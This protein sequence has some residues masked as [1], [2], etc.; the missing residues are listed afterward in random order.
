MK[1][2]V[3]PINDELMERYNIMPGRV[4]YLLKVINDSTGLF[5]VKDRLDTYSRIDIELPFEIFTVFDVD[6]PHI[7][8][9]E[10]C[11]IDMK[12]G[13]HYLTI[14]E[15]RKFLEENKNT[16]NEEGI[17]YYQRIEDY[18]FTESGGWSNNSRIKYDCLTSEFNPLYMHED[19][20]IPAFT[21][22]QYTKGF[23]KDGN[24]YI[25]AHY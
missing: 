15:L 14:K 6:I 13:A 16:L 11:V 18:Y 24:L 5:S 25:T 4:A 7:R 9:T 1:F 17:V 10:Q 20:F 21:C 23:Q 19:E 3:T 22:Y 12:K 2:Y 8:D